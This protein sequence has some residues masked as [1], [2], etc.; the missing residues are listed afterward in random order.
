[1]PAAPAPDLERREL[2]A[3]VLDLVANGD[4][5]A[6]E[7]F[8]PDLHP[9]D[10]GD[11]LAS[12]D[13]DQRV[14]LI[15]VLPLELAS[16][17]LAEMDD[18]EERGDILA[19]LAPAQG[20]ELLQ[21]LEDDDAADLIAELE[22]AEQKLIFDQLPA[23]EAGEIRDLLLFAEESA[24]SLM[25]ASLVAIRA[26]ISAEEAILEVRRQGREVEDF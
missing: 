23:D 8:L 3:R 19:A 17:A 15:K 4:L 12:L 21:E 25:T 16:E 26:D 1:M 6:L 24:G 20:A 7:A 22:P 18:H 14:A 13:E 2:R 11:V 5:A 9:S 10:V